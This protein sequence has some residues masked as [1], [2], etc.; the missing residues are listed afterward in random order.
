MIP[1]GAVL[2]MSTAKLMIGCGENQWDSQDMEH[3][4]RG[5]QIHIENGEG[6]LWVM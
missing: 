1:L 6:E 2:Y 3:A 4:G 5:F